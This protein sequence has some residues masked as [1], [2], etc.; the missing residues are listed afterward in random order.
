MVRSLLAHGA[1]PHVSSGRHQAT[2]LFG[3]AG[4]GNP[5]LLRLMLGEGLE[6]SER[7]LSGETPLHHGAWHPEI[8]RIL[9]ENGADVNA[10]TKGGVTPLF[11]VRGSDRV[12]AGESIRTLLAAGADLHARTSYGVTVLMSRVQSSD[13]VGVRALLQAGAAANLQDDS[14]QTALAIVRDQRRQWR[15][16]FLKVLLRVFSSEYRD[17]EDAELAVLDEIEALLIEAGASA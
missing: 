13:P 4:S 10:R 17:H 1:N 6:A 9:I 11:W 15:A 5:E 12:D 2:A 7:D 16:G 3:A 14:G 8:A